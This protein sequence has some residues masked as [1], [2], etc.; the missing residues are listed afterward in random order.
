[1]AVHVT[2]RTDFDREYVSR[3]NPNIIYHF[4]NETLREEFYHDSWNIDTIE[5]YSVFL[6]QGNYPIKGL[7]YVL[8][9]LP[10]LVE[11][12]EETMLYVAGD[13]ITAHK[14]LKDKIKI[15]GY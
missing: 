12:H 8:D 1:M 4:M 14:T 11:E 6:S 7:H 10:E 15:S 13:V 9:I 2:G 3:I 5:R